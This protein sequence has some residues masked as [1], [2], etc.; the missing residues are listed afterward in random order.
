[1]QWELKPALSNKFVSK[2][3]TTLL[4]SK[5]TILLYFLK[6]SNGLLKSVSPIIIDENSG[7][8]QFPSGSAELTPRLKQ[9]IINDIIPAINK[10]IKEREIDFIQVIGHTD[11]QINSQFSNLDR[12]LE[13]VA[14]GQQLVKTLTPGSNVDL[15]LMRALSVVQELE[16]NTNFQNVQFRAYS[17][18]QLY[19]PSGQISPVNRNSDQT[20]RRIEIRFI[21][22]GQKH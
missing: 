16:K 1:M 19:L 5:L 8:F 9:Y 13:N 10:I 21:P 17:A 4:L 12:H 2:K 22:P 11:G 14:N 3:L 18:A 6:S 7:K 15:G 20:R